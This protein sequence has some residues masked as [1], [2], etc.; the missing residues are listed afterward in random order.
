MVAI[1]QGPDFVEVVGKDLHESYRRLNRK[2]FDGGR[3]G[4]ASSTREVA[5]HP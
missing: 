4:S 3:R 5:L 2:L 1:G